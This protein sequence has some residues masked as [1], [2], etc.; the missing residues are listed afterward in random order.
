MSSIIK[1]RAWKPV[2]SPVRRSVH[3]P[4]CSWA[5][6]YTWPRSSHCDC[7]CLMS[8]LDWL[9]GLVESISALWS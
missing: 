6:V 1:V 8:C 7:T 3:S 2:T 5:R 4:L 9:V